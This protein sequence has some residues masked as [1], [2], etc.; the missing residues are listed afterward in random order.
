MDINLSY[1]VKQLAIDVEIAAMFKEIAAK[2][3]FEV[4]DAVWNAWCACTH[5]IKCADTVF[6]CVLYGA[7]V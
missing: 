5:G 3:E 7:P 6:Y 1:G 4:S 2:A